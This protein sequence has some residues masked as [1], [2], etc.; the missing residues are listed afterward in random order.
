MPNINLFKGILILKISN[1]FF[2]SDLDS[3]NIEEIIRIKHNKYIQINI[4]T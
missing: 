4:S 2:E 1:Y 3:L